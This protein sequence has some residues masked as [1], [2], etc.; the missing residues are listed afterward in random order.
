MQITQPYCV[1][2]GIASKPAEEGT[3]QQKDKKEKIVLYTGTLHRKFG[4]LHLLQAFQMIPDQDMRLVICGIGDSEAEIKAAAEKDPRIC[5]MGQQPRNEVLSLQRQATV[6]V[7]PRQNNE[8]FTKYSFPSKTMEDLASGVP[9]VAYKLD[10][11]PDEY[12][13]YIDYPT[14]DTPNALAKAL[15]L[16]A[17]MHQE[18][19]RSKGEKASKF[20]IEKK[21]A[22]MQTQRILTFVKK[23]QTLQK[24]REVSNE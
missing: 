21:N 4:I 9:V 11:M 15:C 12:D 6:L 14:N 3:A 16:I 1:M 22:K 17:N 8:E 24:D 7:N 18:D 5:F 19:W 20:V 23:V 13:E 2:E 10:G